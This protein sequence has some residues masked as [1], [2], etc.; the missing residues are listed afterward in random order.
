MNLQIVIYLALLFCLSEFILML[1][2]RSK[3]RVRKVKKDKM[4]LLLFWIVISI[5]ITIGF[6]K[7]NYSLWSDFNSSI[8][9]LGL[10]IFATGVA[11]RW[12]AI[13]QLSKE[14][15]VDVAVSKKHQLHT[16]GMYKYV[17]H[18]SYL[19]LLLI[20]LGLSIAMNS[21]ISLLIVS[22]PIL[23]VTLYRIQI[24]ESI[25]R[26]EFGQVYENYMQT[27]HRIIPKIY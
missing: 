20:C 8:A 9:L 4:S 22:L 19:G 2:R 17:R 5:S 11:I 14:F 18:P 13:L 12:T 27:T 26:V 6:F 1:T 3:K 15:T 25:L 23:F 24:E 7:A 16:T 10:I 21:I